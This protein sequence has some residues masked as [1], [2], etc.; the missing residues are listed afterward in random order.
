MTWQCSL[1]PDQEKIGEIGIWNGIVI[2]RIGEPDRRG[3]V[4]QRMFSRIG[5]LY[6]PRTF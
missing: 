3:S 4:R 5:N 6:L 1:Q 2:R